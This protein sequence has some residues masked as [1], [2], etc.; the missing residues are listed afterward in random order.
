MAS[1]TKKRSLSGGEGRP[2]FSHYQA[3]IRGINQ[4]GGRWGR[5]VYWLLTRHRGRPGVHTEA[6]WRVTDTGAD[7]DTSDRL[8]RECV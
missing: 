3:E 1:F 4:D 7:S 6:T 8:P 5:S 2:T